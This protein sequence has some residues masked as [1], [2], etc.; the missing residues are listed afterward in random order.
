VFVVGTDV[1][2]DKRRECERN[3]IVF[4]VGTEERINK[5]KNNF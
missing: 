2:G 1:S 5:F 4:L 3:Y